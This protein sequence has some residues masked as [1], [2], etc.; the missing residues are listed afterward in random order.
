MSFKTLYP[1][2]KPIAS[3]WIE[4]GDG[5]DIYVEQVGNPNG[6]PVIF[7]HGGPGSSC[8]DHHRCFFNPEKYHVILMDQR[9][10]G[11]SRPSGELKHN[12]TA[13]LIADMELIRKKLVIDA[14]LLFGGSWGATLALLYAQQHSEQVLSLIL[15]GTFLARLQDANWFFK[16]GGANQ[17]FPDAWQRFISHIPTAEHENLL[18]AYHQRLNSDDLRIQQAA[19]REWD[20]WGGAVVLGDEFDAAELEGDV[21]ETAI[22]QTRIETHYGMNRYFIEEN[23]ILNNVSC[24]QDIPCTIIHGEKDFMCPIDSSKTLANMLPNAQL[25]RLYNSNHLAH[26]DE[27]IDALVSATDSMISCL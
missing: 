2:I 18:A 21:P 9:G 25:V 3:E 1:A 15:R 13:H 6:I 8:K 26:G 7:L 23:Q 11:R 27:M 14:W 10:A 22:A 16:D 19:S 24:L 4:T 20:A 12:T 17:L 5:H